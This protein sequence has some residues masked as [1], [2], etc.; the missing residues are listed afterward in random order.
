MLRE[1]LLAILGSA[2]D[3]VDQQ[4]SQLSVRLR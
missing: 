1:D 4:T 3:G 2:G